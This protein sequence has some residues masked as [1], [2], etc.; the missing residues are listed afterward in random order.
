MKSQVIHIEIGIEYIE[1]HLDGKLK[2]ETVASAVHYSKYH[3]HGM[4]T[5]IVDMTIRDSQWEI[6]VR[7]EMIRRAAVK[8]LL[9]KHGGVKY[10]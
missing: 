5:Y 4:F 2:V 6:C 3:L 9:E 10:L 8:A 7:K 1:T